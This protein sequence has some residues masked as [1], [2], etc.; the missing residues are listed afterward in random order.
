MPSFL[1]Y[2]YWHHYSNRQQ[3]FFYDMKSRSRYLSALLVF[4]V[5]FFLNRKKYHRICFYY[6]YLYI[7]HAGLSS[8]FPLHFLGLFVFFL[9]MDRVTRSS[10]RLQRFAGTQMYYF[11]CQNLSIIWGKISHR[12]IVTKKKRERGKQKRRKRLFASNTNA[13]SVAL[14]YLKSPQKG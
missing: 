13:S 1:S 11:Q 9:R 2:I 14:N 3:R 10:A 7:S 4:F 5:C 12:A 8:H 6:S